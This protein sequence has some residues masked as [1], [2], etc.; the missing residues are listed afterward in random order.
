MGDNHNMDMVHFLEA[1][2]IPAFPTKAAI[3]AAN[4]SLPMLLGWGDDDFR[5]FF[6]LNQ[7]PKGPQLL[8]R[9]Q[10]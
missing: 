6:E 1:H 5:L 8:S 9:G 2:G 10:F 7:I 4:V 3:L